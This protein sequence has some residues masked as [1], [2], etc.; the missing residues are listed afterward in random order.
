MNSGSLREVIFK[1]LSLFVLPVELSE[2]NEIS[3]FLSCLLLETEDFLEVQAGSIHGGK[4][5]Q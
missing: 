2:L 4:A 3:L 1:A 5:P